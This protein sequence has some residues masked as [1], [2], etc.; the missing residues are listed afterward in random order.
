[1]KVNNLGMKLPNGKEYG[2]NSDER[3][4]YAPKKFDLDQKFEE[5]KRK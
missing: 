3:E 5:I 4:T 2:A 1:M